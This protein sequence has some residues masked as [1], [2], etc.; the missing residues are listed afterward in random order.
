[1]KFARSPI[2]RVLPPLLVASLFGWELVVRPRSADHT[3][4][5]TPA[6]SLKP[7]QAHELAE[8]SQILIQEG[9]DEEA[10]DPSLKLYAAFPENHVYIG[11]IAEI[12]DRLGRYGEE[13]QFWEKYV[14][15]A[16]MPLEACPQIGQAYGKQGKDQEAIDAFERCLAFDS[17]STTNIFYLAHAL[18]IAQQFGRAAEMYQ[19]GLALSPTNVD[20]LVGLGRAQ[21]RLDQLAQ[22]KKTVSQVLARSPDNVDALLVLGLVE[23]RQGHLR[24]AKQVLERGVKL[25][26]GYSDFHIALG[27]LAEKQ[28]DIAE[29]V[30]QYN[31]VI[32]LKPGNEE[33]RA[34]R[35]ALRPAG[36]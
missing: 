33:I 36:R 12:Y 16:P 14:E 22:A 1:M 32:E 28:N 27:R 9:R 6:A 29:A 4:G 13:A 8:T 10:L 5:A 25:S 35:N 7:E 21:F 11:Q 3:G 23:M 20:L 26:E 24:A 30:R 31:R 2:G 34:R 18:E 15:H 17:E 19:R